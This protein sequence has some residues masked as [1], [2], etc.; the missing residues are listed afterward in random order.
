MGYA[1]PLLQRVGICS[2][3]CVLECNSMSFG[4]VVEFLILLSGIRVMM[5]VTAQVN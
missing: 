5:M 2:G 1:G 3:Q 4:F